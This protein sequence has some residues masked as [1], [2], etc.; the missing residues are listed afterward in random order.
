MSVDAIK[1]YADAV[2]GNG[3]AVVSS[4]LSRNEVHKA[5]EEAFAAHATSPAT[6]ASTAL[7]APS[8]RAGAE[9]C[10]NDASAEHVHV[11]FA[12]PVSNRLHGAV[13]AQLLGGATHI[14]WS[15][16]GETPLAQAVRAH[17]GLS[18]MAFHLPHPD[19]TLLSVLIKAPARGAAEAVGTIKRAVNATMERLA[20]G[21]EEGE[22]KR[23]V[24]KARM[25]AATGMETR[26]GRLS[27][28]E[29]AVSAAR[30]HALRC[31]AEDDVC[32]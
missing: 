19:A 26:E 28:I 12:T 8:F 11:A 7:A 6:S 25:L 15:H 1:S 30:A 32:L 4:G 13:V 18:A 2:L 16:G 10:I 20:G 24:A 22:L 21:I 14:K 3:I 5:V 17:D 9:T 23:A 31:Y 29:S 27:A